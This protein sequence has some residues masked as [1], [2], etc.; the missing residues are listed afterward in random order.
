MLSKVLNYFEG[1][2]LSDHKRG[3]RPIFIV[4]VPQIQRYN[5]LTL[6]ID[7]NAYLQLRFL[8]GLHKPLRLQN[9]IFLVRLLIISAVIVL[10]FSKCFTGSSR[11]LS[12][13]I[14]PHAP[15]IESSQ[16]GQINHI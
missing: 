16:V 5:L 1:L 7:I 15:R 11:L 8:R 3:E 9:Q 6:T 13:W 10:I 4:E 12:R 2:Q 14:S